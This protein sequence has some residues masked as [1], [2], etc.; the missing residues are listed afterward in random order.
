MITTR[1]NFIL[2]TG[3]AFI[4]GTMNRASADEIP[5]APPQD[6]SSQLA[7]SGFNPLSNN[8]AVLAVIGDAHICLMNDLPRY[9]TDKWDDGLINEINNLIP[10]VT[11]LAIAGDLI[12]QHSVSV[13]GSRYPSV[14]LGAREEFRLAKQEI[15]RFRSGMRVWAVPGNHDTDVTDT[16]AEIW[17]EELELP[18]YQKTILGGV[19]I[20]LLNSGNGGMMDARQLAWFKDEAKLIPLNQEVIIIAHHPSFFYLWS[21]TGLKRILADTFANHQ[22]VVWVVGGHGHAFGDYMLVNGS[23]RFIQMEVTSANPKSNNDGNAPG[24]ALLALQDGR[25]V[26]RMF[27][28]LKETGFRSLKPPSQIP[29]E[30]AKWAFD[31]IIYPAQIFEHG[32]YKRADHLVAFKGVDLGCHWINM[33]SLTVKVSTAKFQGKVDTF[34]FGADLP[35]GF[36]PFPTC[37]FSPTGVD[38]SWLEV[39]FPPG[40]GNGLYKVSIPAALRNSANV[41]VRLHTPLTY[42]YHGFKVFGWALAA[43]G[44]QLSGFE[45]WLSSRYRT[46]EPITDS[47]VNGNTPGSNFANIANFGFNLPTTLT[48]PPLAGASLPPNT[49]TGLPQYSRTIRQILDFRFARRTQS[50]NPGIVY[51]VE[52]STD[53]SNWLAVDEARLA[54]AP[55]ESGWEQVTIGLPIVNGGK[56]FC[57]VR[58]ETAAGANTQF[59][60]WSQNVAVT[61]GTPDDRNADGVSDLLQFAFDLDLNSGVPRSYDPVRTVR[62]AGLP[63]QSTRSAKMSRILFPRMSATSNPGIHYRLMASTNLS[64]WRLLQP[65]EY[66]ERVVRTEGDW[67]EVEVVIFDYAKVRSFYKFMLE[68]E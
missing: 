8:S 51:R 15:N 36:L 34:V 21:E 55:V 25:V 1:R 60:T 43:T 10:T 58:V 46:L 29:S 2:T 18:P 66:N 37:S 39:P 14:L 19:P 62:K 28:T 65:I 41:F 67:E 12:S 53:L 31:E 3:T 56:V 63:I 48:P 33:K 45:K 35:A 17:R 27:R 50:S 61:G 59:S 30:R 24:Y 42:Y 54:I 47:V 22:A 52:Q 40:K 5:V 49:I 26:H 4:G 6:I 16:D 44:S 23:T 64:D 7:A 20:F 68:T 57:R 38:G 11:D 9:W 32:F 13:G